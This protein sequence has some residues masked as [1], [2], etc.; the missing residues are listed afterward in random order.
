MI[1]QLDENGNR[2]GHWEWYYENGQISSKG[3]YKEGQ[4]HGLWV[5]YWS[6]GQLY[7]KGEF[8]KGK[9]IGLWYEDRFND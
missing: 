3:G 4:Q 7:E 2:N 9:N 8:K 1:N 6:D 5:V